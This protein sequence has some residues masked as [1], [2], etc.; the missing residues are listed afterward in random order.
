M[1]MDWK[2]IDDAIL[3][4]T[5]RD[6]LGNEIN[7]SLFRLVRFIPM[8]YMGRGSDSMMYRAGKDFAK[9]LNLKSIDD[10]IKFCKDNKIGIVSLVSENPLIVRVEDCIT[11]K[12]LPKIGQ[13]YCYF[14]AGF[15]AGCIESIFNKKCQ[16]KEVCCAGL[17]H[18]YCEFEIKFL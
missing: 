1:F 8:R 18:D 9:M 15:I 7:I 12:G 17:G 13:P 3:N 5:P 4:P 2:A 10:V 6:S 11:C 14:E 16:A